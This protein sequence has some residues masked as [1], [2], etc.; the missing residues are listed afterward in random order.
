MADRPLVKPGDWICVG[1][2]DCVVARIFEPSH[3]EGDAEVVF[4]PVKPTNRNVRWEGDGWEFVD[5]G[6]FGGYADKYP[7]L[8]SYVQVLKRGKYA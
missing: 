6:D 4:D 2:T 3:V 1:R 5:S 7:R 8:R